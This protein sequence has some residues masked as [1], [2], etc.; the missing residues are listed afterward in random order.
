MKYCGAFLR[1]FLIYFFCIGF[2]IGV[3]ELDHYLKI[4]TLERIYL[5]KKNWD[6]ID[7]SFVLFPLI[8]VLTVII[9]WMFYLTYALAYLQRKRIMYCE[10]Q[11]YHSREH[12]ITR[13]QAK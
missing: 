9:V 11:D 13:N 10:V 3:Y 2:I 7:N 5:I 12:Y 8:V 1:I 4:E 6:E